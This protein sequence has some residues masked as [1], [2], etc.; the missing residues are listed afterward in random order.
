MRTNIQVY[1][2]AGRLIETPPPYPT[3]SY[4]APN[5]PPQTKALPPPSLSVPNRLGAFSSGGTSG[6]SASASPYAFSAQQPTQ[7]LS[8]ASN[9]VEVYA[10]DQDRELSRDYYYQDDRRTESALLAEKA[11][12]VLEEV[13]REERVRGAHSAAAAAAG[14]EGGLNE[15]GNHARNQQ[16]LQD[17]IFKLK[18]AQKFFAEDKEPA[19]EAKLVEEQSRLLGFQAA[20]ETEDGGGAT[21]LRRARRERDDPAVSAEGHDVQG[22]EAAGL[23]GA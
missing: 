18:T 20:L 10:R 15:N 4:P 3:A 7:H 17:P 12:L 9:L 14:P 16:G 22:Q 5:T 11:L 6:R 13:E 2:S 19:L 21:P 23:E 8:L 1:T